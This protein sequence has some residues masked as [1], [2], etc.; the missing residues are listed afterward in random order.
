MRL[1]TAETALL[2][3]AVPGLERRLQRGLQ[4]GRRWEKKLCNGYRDLETLCYSSDYESSPGNMGWTANLQGCGR[5]VYRSLLAM[6]A[7]GFFFLPSQGHLLLTSKED[8]HLFITAGLAQHTS[9]HVTSDPKVLDTSFSTPHN[10]FW[11]G[12]CAVHSRVNVKHCMHADCSYWACFLS[13]IGCGKDEQYCRQYRKGHQ[14]KS[15]HKPKHYPVNILI[16]GFLKSINSRH[17]S[18]QLRK[19]LVVACCKGK[20]LLDKNVDGCIT[21]ICT[22]EVIPSAHPQSQTD[23]IFFF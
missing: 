22:A 1:P 14:Q 12:T 9:L 7:T 15:M 21:T 20:V 6:T 3:W 23:K 19:T 11:S 2:L 10:V 18:K 16:N 8:L 13:N 4:W 17:Y 5:T